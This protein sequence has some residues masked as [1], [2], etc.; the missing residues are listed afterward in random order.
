MDNLAKKLN[1]TNQ[2]GWYN[3]TYQQLM[4]NGAN[5]LLQRNKRSPSKLLAA[6][7]PEYPILF[8]NEMSY[9]SDELCVD[10]LYFL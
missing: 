10:T 2:M 1:I 5:R 6:V 4:N 3:I 8:P 7:Y 9:E